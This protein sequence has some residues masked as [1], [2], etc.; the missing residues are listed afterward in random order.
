MIEDI[1]SS[2]TGKPGIGFWEFISKKIPNRSPDSIR[3]RWYYNLLKDDRVKTMILLL[4]EINIK[5]KKKSE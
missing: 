1:E 3:L 2:S 5:K 4:K